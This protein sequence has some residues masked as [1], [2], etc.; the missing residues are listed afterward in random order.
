M[1]GKKFLAVIMAVMMIFSICSCATADSGESDKKETVSTSSVETSKEE[2]AEATET[3]ETGEMA[4]ETAS[5]EEKNGLGLT[6][7]EM[8]EIYVAIEE[9]LQKEY[10]DVNNIKV[11][12]FSIPT[13]DES[14]NFFYEHFTG[15]LY[16]PSKETEEDIKST[17]VD[18]TD[19]QSIMYIISYAFFNYLEENDKEYIVFHFQVDDSELTLSKELITSNVFADTE[20]AATE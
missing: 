6:E 14:W 5:D 20:T 11:E 4:E 18:M 7:S 9:I 16:Q 10:L 12:D 13:D 19:Q 1:K 17:T 2:E 3:E 8:Q 15:R